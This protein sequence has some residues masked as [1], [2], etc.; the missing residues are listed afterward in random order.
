M[1]Q[2]T[3]TV[4]VATM[5]EEASIEECVRRI[6]GVYPDLCEV[7]VIDGGSDRTREIVLRLCE[8][9]SRLRYLR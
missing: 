1:E 2:L 5:N 6:F 9:F 8:E 3:L 7:L 4:L